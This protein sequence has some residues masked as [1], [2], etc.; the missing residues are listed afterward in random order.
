MSRPDTAA[1]SKVWLPRWVWPSQ[2]V[3]PLAAIVIFFLFKV[4]S[5][6]PLARFNLY[7]PDPI[8]PWPKLVGDGLVWPTVL[9]TPAVVAKILPSQTAKPEISPSMVFPP[10]NPEISSPTGILRQPAKPQEKPPAPT[11]ETHTHH[12]SRA[13]APPSSPT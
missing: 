1:T 3:H 5:Q 11:S 12:R 2:L 6:S 9:P 10:Q 4:L 8:I 7:W 13:A